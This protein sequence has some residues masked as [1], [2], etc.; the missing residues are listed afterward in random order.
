MVLTPKWG[1]GVESVENGLFRVKNTFFWVK[2]DNFCSYWRF[3]VVFISKYQTEHES[4]E[5]SAKK[6]SLVTKSY[7]ILELFFY[8][9]VDT[10]HLLTLWLSSN[11]CQKLWQNRDY[12]FEG[13]NLGE[14]VSKSQKK[15][16]YHGF[17]QKCKIRPGHRVVLTENNF[18]MVLPVIHVQ[19]KVSWLSQARFMSAKSTC[20]KY[21]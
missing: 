17:R 14:T 2:I 10:P 13:S 8:Q 15:F 1:H 16:K 3:F 4:G 11:I 6:T 7:E 20:K 12:T 5:S 19:I 21:L 9:N 18:F